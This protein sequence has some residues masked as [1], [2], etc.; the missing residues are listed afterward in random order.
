MFPNL[1]L[2]DGFHVT[3][4]SATTLSEHI[5]FSSLFPA[6]QLDVINPFDLELS[7]LTRNTVGF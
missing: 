7:L 4:M 1:P 3:Q 2:Q 6:T 5:S